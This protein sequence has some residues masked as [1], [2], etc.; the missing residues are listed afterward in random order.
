MLFAALLCMSDSTAETEPEKRAPA[1][2][3]SA[4][5]VPMT[6]QSTCYTC[7]VAAVQSVFAFFGLEFR[8]DELSRLLGAGPRHGT[9]YRRIEKLARKH[10]FEVEIRTGLTSKEL[11][12]Y[13]DSGQPVICLLQAW[14]DEKKDYEKDWDDGHY[15]VA[16]GYDRENVF[17]MDPST[18]GN[19]TYVPKAE[20]ERRWHDTDGKEKVV[21]F[22]MMLRKGKPSYDPAVVKKM[23]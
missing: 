23:E 11:E 6:R 21:H 8:E 15:V 3:A 4:I 1:L 22:G 2:P 9:R 5:R 20:F 16:I 14:P 12:H 7:G 17:F 18:L 13:L 10:G 19:Y